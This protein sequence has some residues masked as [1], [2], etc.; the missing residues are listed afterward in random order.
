[1]STAS[2]APATAREAYERG[3]E[4]GL[5]D[6]ACG[7]LDLNIEQTME[8]Q[9]RLLEEQLALLASSGLGKKLFQGQAPRNAEELRAFPLTS[10]E[11]YLDTLGEKR[12]DVLPAPPRTWVKTTGRSGKYETKWIPITQRTYETTSVICLALLL[13]SS[14]DRRGDVQLSP[15]SR[16]L[17]M[18]APPPYSSSCM[19]SVNLQWPFNHFPPPTPETDA[20]PFEQRIGL[21]FSTGVREGVDY[22]ISIASLLAGIGE[23]FA[24]RQPKKSLA[25][26]LQNPSVFFRMSRAALKARI[27]GRPMYPKDVWKLKGLATAGMDASLFRERIRETWGRYPLEFLASSEGLVIATQSWDFTTMTFFPSLNFLEFVPDNELKKEE[28]DPGYKPGTVLLDEVEAGERY[29]IVLTNFHGGALVRYRTGDIVQITGLR[30]ER[31]G[32]NLPQMAFSTRQ[33]DVIS[34]AGFAVITEKSIWQAIEKAGIQY[35][36]WTTRKEIRDG[37]P[38]VHLRIEPK[39]GFAMTEQEAQ[40]RIHQ[41]LREIDQDWA[42]MEDMASLTPLAVTFLPRGTFAG[43]T[44]KKRA[45]GAEMAH[46]KPVHMNANDGVVGMLLEAAAEAAEATEEAAPAGVR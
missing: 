1:M 6:F 34:I 3:G 45:Q 4:A 23:T 14:A 10:Y 42:N 46:L 28:E 18:F 32:V 2:A 5:W 21:G 31:T 40:A 27:A 15:N 38:L 17:E 29:E 7:F 41:A 26:K 8:I 39:A 25:Q 36:E 24:Q 16:F 13:L 9:H 43:Y 35:E 22:A 12:E 11:D 19:R 37:A 33:S 44:D 20:L 30:N